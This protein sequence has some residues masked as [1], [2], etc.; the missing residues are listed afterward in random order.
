MNELTNAQFSG[1][2]RGNF[3]NDVSQEAYDTFKAGALD[4]KL[5]RSKVLL[6]DIRILAED[7][8]SLKGVAFKMTDDAFVSLVKVL[9]LTKGVMGT[10]ESALG[11]GGRDKIVDLMR[12]AMSGKEGRSE[13]TVVLN[14]TTN[15]I[16]DVRRDA[17]NVL[18]TESYF[19]LFEDVMNGH[20]N[21]N[22]KRMS[23]S[24]NGSVEIAVVNNSWEFQVAKL[25]NE[26]FHSGL[27][28]INKPNQ[29]VINPFMER[30]VCTNGMVVSETGSSIILKSTDAVQLAGFYEQV[31]NITDLHGAENEFKARVVRMMKTVASYG[32]MRHAMT[33]LKYWL[34]SEDSQVLQTMNEYLPLNEVR[35]AY[36]AATGMDIENEQRYWKRAETNQTVWQLVNGL[37]DLSSHP[38]R[39]GL[40]LKGGNRAVFELQKVAGELAF[41]KEY[42]L[43]AEMPSIFDTKSRIQRDF[44]GDAQTPDSMK[45]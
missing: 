24:Q 40:L 39:H 12:V 22:I 10:F 18:S 30:L 8:L 15:A 9:G 23:M 13:V 37:T 1:R 16:V 7:K 38:E 21:M 35:A 44:E 31:R 43:E 2:R 20:S 32:E 34:S 17:M 42:D 14:R 28:F 4:N 19:Q 45:D 27:V 36:V 5:I 11:K 41:K 29:T 26:F 6:S 3:G 25:N 33:N